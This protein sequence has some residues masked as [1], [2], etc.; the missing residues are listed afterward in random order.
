M[1]KN[2]MAA[3]VLGCAAG[4][5]PAATLPYGPMNDVSVSTVAGWGYSTCYSETY[6][7][8]SGASL[9]SKL[10]AC[11]SNPDSY[12]ILAGRAVGSATYDVLAA[13]TIGFLS[14]LNTGYQDRTTTVANNGAEWY[15]ADNWSVGF[16]GLG[17]SVY[18]SS[19]DTTGQAERD[20]L[21]WHT[22]DHTGGWRS[23]NHTGLNYSTS[24]LKEILVADVAPVPVP[25]TGLLLLGGLGGLA[26]LRRRKRA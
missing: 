9:S 6:S 13:T 15:N 21:C 26:A 5:A 11:A 16:A 20:R 12:V 25:A 18:K 4:A 14:G 7:T 24:W 1:L 22:I 17:D 23:G 3:A 10:A 19:C 2:L 8:P